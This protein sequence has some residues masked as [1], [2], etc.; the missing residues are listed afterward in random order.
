MSVSIPQLPLARRSD[1]VA[2]VANG[3]VDWEV[4]NLKDVLAEQV[5]GAHGRDK[6]C[7][8]G[9]SLHLMSIVLV[10]DT[11]EEV[12]SCTEFETND[13]AEEEGGEGDVGA[14][15]GD[16]HDEGEDAH[17]EVEEGC[18]LLASSKRGL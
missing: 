2:E 13:Q 12:F 1:K 8:A 4:C 11:A 6:E 18:K 16:K 10:V 7:G 9:A 15:R 5:E 3:N 14:E 17:E